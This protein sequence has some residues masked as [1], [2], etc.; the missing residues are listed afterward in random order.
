MT[1]H[2]ALVLA[3]K[4]EE[5]ER[6]KIGSHAPLPPEYLTALRQA[7]LVRLN[8]MHANSH[9]T[10]GYGKSSTLHIARFHVE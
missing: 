3:G 10:N 7:Q 4:L 1:L 8:N 2:N 5:I 6:G 9:G